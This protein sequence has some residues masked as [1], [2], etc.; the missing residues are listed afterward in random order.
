MAC[1]SACARSL[2]L[3]D[4]PSGWGSEYTPGATRLEVIDMLRLAAD[5]RVPVYTHMRTA[6]RIEPGPSLESISEVIGA[7]A[8]TGASSRARPSDIRLTLRRVCVSAAAQS[9]D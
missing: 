5:R 1:G 8:V 9:R 4:W 6:G 2:M 7:A 3:V